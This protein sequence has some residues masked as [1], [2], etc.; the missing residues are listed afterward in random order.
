MEKN[1][2]NKTKLLITAIFL[3]GIFFINA[4][5]TEA[6]PYVPI[7]ALQGTYLNTYGMQTSIATGAQTAKEVGQV[8]G[9]SPFAPGPGVAAGLAPTSHD[10]VARQI[11]N[12]SLT[13]VTNSIMGWIGGGFDVL[14]TGESGPAFVT[15]PAGLLQ[16]IADNTV[17][18]FISGNLLDNVLCKP[19]T[20][21]SFGFGLPGFGGLNIKSLLNLKY[22][23][24]GFQFSSLCSLGSNLNDPAAYDEFTSPGGFAKGGWEGWFQIIQPQNNPYGAFLAADTELNS[25]IA[26]EQGNQLMQLNWGQGFFSQTAEDGTI[27]TPGIT[28]AMGLDRVLNTEIAELE[29]AGSFDRVLQSLV[30][31]LATG[32]LGA[33]T[34]DRQGLLGFT[35][36]RT[37]ESG[38]PPIQPRN[39]LGDPPPIPTNLQVFA[40][41]AEQVI[42]S[43]NAVEMENGER[44][45][46]YYVY[47]DDQRIFTTVNTF[48]N[49][50]ENIK[51]NTEYQYQVSAFK[52][53]DNNPIP[54]E[55]GKSGRVSV[56]T[57]NN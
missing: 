3:I 28:I 9:I 17:S 21:P 19:F 35:R 20:V 5:K 41:S 38:L 13:Q 56:T 48:H 33:G 23:S 8:P 30:N 29:T 37:G 40:L 10:F 46:G 1:K 49:D 12:Q 47:R 25:R 4:N 34:Q 16:G 45:D 36:D 43:W 18:S 39:L 7:D 44:V 55:S 24:S 32:A 27:I 51:P 54:S 2:K 52:Y 22:N 14:N 42:L 50:F 57:L 26:S 15:D 6:Q 31:Q 11:A 53:Y